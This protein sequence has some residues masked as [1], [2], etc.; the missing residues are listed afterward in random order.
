MHHGKEKGKKMGNF[1][2]SNTS[3]SFSIE[4][5]VNTRD[6]HTLMGLSV[7][8][9]INGVNRRKKNESQNR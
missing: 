8:Y 2:L 3:E 6:M 1:E 5:A 7:T 4:S 9:T